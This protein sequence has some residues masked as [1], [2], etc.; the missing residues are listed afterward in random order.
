MKLLLLIAIAE[1]LLLGAMC[2][3]SK[4]EKQASAEAD[5]W[6]N[7]TIKELLCSN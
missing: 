3:P 6:V 2:L 1:L 7:Q 4:A 5:A